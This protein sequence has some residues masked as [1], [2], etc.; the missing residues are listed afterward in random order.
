MTPTQFCVKYMR[1]KENFWMNGRSTSNVH[2][3][4]EEW[5]I[6]WGRTFGF[7]VNHKIVVKLSTGCIKKCVVTTWRG[8]LGLPRLGT[9]TEEFFSGTSNTGPHVDEVHGWNWNSWPGFISKP[10]SYEFLLIP[11]NFPQL[12]GINSH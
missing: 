8:G 10:K 4:M 3:C 5:S 12:I 1:N 7:E 2:T 6:S 11:I 9:D